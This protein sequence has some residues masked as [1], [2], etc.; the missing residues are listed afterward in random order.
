MSLCGGGNINQ[1]R[2]PRDCQFRIASEP[3]NDHMGTRER[4]GGGI[5]EGSPFILRG[6]RV[7]VGHQSGLWDAQHPVHR[8]VENAVMLSNKHHG[9]QQNPRVVKL[10]DK[11]LTLA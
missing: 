5:E 6:T 2:N 7:A 8:L 11:V 9:V 3:N 1:S 10:E 4:N